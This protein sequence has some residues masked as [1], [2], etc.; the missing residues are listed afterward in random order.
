MQLPRPQESGALA[1]VLAPGSQAE[2]FTF[3]CCEAVFWYTWD[4][5]MTRV[6][7]FVQWTLDSLK[8]I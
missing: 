5:P 2:I 7:F 3:L 8:R 6:I 1:G 4:F